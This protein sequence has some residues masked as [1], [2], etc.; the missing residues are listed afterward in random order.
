MVVVG[1]VF[2]GTE[3]LAQRPP[4]AMDFPQWR[5]GQGDPGQGLEDMELTCLRPS[6]VVLT[7]EQGDMEAIGAWG[8][9]LVHSFLCHWRDG[10]ESGR[11]SE[12]RWCNQ[13]AESGQPY[14]FKLTFPGPDGEVYVEV[15]ST[16]KR[17]RAFINL[18]ANELDFALKERERYQVFRVYG[19]GDAHNVRLCR[20]R[21][22][23][24]KL[25]A[26]DLEIFLFV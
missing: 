13:K 11:P 25:H 8:E 26:K 22:L 9:Q 24:Q 17:D 18:S 20:I 16:V 21:N 7:D 5:P 3:G 10:Q 12:V 4:L 14:D 6:T 19:V 2:Q 1:S 15:K 23:A